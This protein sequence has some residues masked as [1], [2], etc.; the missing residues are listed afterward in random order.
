[1]ATTALKNAKPASTYLLNLRA[2]LRQSDKP[3]V[4]FSSGTLAIE[5]RASSDSIFAVVRRPGKG[6]VAVRAAFVTGV[7]SCSVV[8]AEPGEAARIVVN[9]DAGAY[10][11]SFTAEKDALERLR[12]LTEFTPAVTMR[13][14]FLPRDVYPMDPNDDPMGAH[15]EVAAQQRGLNAGLIFFRIDEPAFGNVLY[16]QNLTRLNEYFKATGTAPK[17]AVGGSWPELGYA[18]PTAEKGTDEALQAGQKY[19]LSDAILVFR[20]EERSHERESARQFIQMLGAAYQMLDLP[21]VEYRDWVGRAQKA[22]R[23]LDRAPEATIKHYGHR[24]VHP[25]TAAEYPDFMV[26]MSVVAA[27]HDWGKWQGEPVPLEAELKAGLRRFYDAKLSTFRR[28]LPNVGDDKNADA[29]DSWYLYHPLVNLGILASWHWTATT[30]RATCSSTASTMPCARRSTSSIA[31][32][33]SMT[34]PTSVSLMRP[35]RQMAAVRPTSAVST[36]GS[37]FRRS[38]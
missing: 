10:L 15:G 5:V 7:F 36:P 14:P 6:G 2:A 25:Y 13:I 35:Q 3:L 22:V 21:P 34:S 12:I 27:L 37:C 16:L 11:I 4:E 31:G 8:R 32:L 18:A 29:V 26:Q 9:S 19:T 23:D 28:Y 17:D 38:N 24:Y 30:R 33:S 20:H 1:M